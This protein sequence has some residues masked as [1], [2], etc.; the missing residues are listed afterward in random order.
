M[1]PNPDATLIE[2]MGA[3]R[4]LEVKDS[5]EVWSQESG[6]VCAIIHKGYPDAKNVAL[7]GC[8]SRQDFADSKKPKRG[9]ITIV[10]KPKPTEE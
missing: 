9:K 8:R 7:K 2:D 6:K 4:V 10:R 3:Y 1:Q 5:Y